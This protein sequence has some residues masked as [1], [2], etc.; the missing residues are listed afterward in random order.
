MNDCACL[1]GTFL[2]HVKTASVF[3]HWLRLVAATVLAFIH[4]S[5]SLLTMPISDFVGLIRRHVGLFWKFG[6]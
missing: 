3:F 2:N 4:W 6:L 1:L 5:I